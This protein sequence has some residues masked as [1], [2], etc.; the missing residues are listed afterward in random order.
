MNKKQNSNV[1]INVLR[2]KYE[3]F[4]SV[5]KLNSLLGTNNNPDS[6]D[7]ENPDMID[8][9]KILI[10]V[11]DYTPVIRGDLFVKHPGKTWTKLKNIKIINDLKK[12]IFMKSPHATPRSNLLSSIRSSSI[13]SFLVSSDRL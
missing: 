3:G 5:I 12:N 7:L 2:F 13:D 8:D 9:S 1:Q 4:S 10:V 11:A 6:K